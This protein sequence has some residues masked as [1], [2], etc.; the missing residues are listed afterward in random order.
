MRGKPPTSKPQKN[1]QEQENVLNN[2]PNKK[3]KIEIQQITQIQEKP[4]IRNQTPYTPN[5]Q[6][7]LEMERAEKIKR[8]EEKEQVWALNKLCR[9][10]L[11]ENSKEWLKR[12]RQRQEEKER[13]E[14]LEKARI[15]SRKAKIKEIEKNI[16]KGLNKIP[17]EEKK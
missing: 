5:L 3:L 16:E 15:L 17:P 7:V 8:K 11:E 1:K 12:K 13:L 6:E 14:R 2:Q 9:K 10:F 4:K